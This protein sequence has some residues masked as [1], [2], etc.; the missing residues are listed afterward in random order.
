MRA[1]ECEE[2]TPTN[3]CEWCLTTLPTPAMAS[4]TPYPEG[5]RLCFRCWKGLAVWLKSLGADG[6][7]QAVPPPPAEMESYP[8]K[9]SDGH[10]APCPTCAKTQPIYVMRRDGTD[11]TCCAVCS[12][13][14]KMERVAR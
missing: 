9:A 3:P 5:C 11:H 12:R 13:V 4:D 1:D 6:L 14:L 8:I 7:G 10:V 2:V